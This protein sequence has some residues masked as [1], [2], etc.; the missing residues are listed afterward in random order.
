VTH[1]YPDQAAGWH[2]LGVALLDFHHGE[3]TAEIVVTSDLWE[4]EATPVAAYYRPD[5]QA[6]P[7]L[8]R[9][10]L[11]LC[12][13]RVLDLGAG[14]GR[15]AIELQRAG[16]DVVAVDPMPEAVEIMRDRGVADARQGDLNALRGERFDTVLMLMHGLGV[17]GDL[18]GLGRLFEELPKILDPGGRLVCDSADLAAVLG[19]ESPEVLDELLDPDS[20]LGEVEFK[21]RY[22]SLEGPRYPWIFVDPETLEIIAN[23]AGLEVEITTRG[24]RGSFVATLTVV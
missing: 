1:P 7:A 21:L 9:Q 2:P 10:A 6:L 12:R 13:G 4:D 15:H 11:G 18:H 14:A 24:E 8:E 5:E 17:V 22:R 20:Y 23:A 16:H 3:T 19:D